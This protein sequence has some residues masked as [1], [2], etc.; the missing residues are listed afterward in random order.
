MNK[1]IFH[2]FGDF[3]ADGIAVKLLSDNIKASPSHQV[4]CRHFQNF[5]ENNKQV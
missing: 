2:D 5:L 1:A 3:D 4:V